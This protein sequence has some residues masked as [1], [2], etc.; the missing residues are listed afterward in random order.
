[1]RFL[2]NLSELNLYLAFDLFIDKRA[3]PK[4]PYNHF[5]IAPL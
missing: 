2:L 4:V 3:E 1:M 5:Y